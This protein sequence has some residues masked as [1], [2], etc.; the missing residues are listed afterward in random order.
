LVVAVLELMVQATAEQIPCSARSHLLAVVAV[1]HTIRTTH[2]A[3]V[4]VAVAQVELCQ[5]K[6]LEQVQATH[7]VLAHRKVPQVAQVLET[8]LMV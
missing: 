1:V 4:Q 3:E 8:Q 5:V 2:L 7:R 6:R